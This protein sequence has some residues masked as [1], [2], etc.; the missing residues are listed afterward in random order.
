[1]EERRS[2]ARRRLSIP[3]TLAASPEHRLPQA[4][5]LDISLDGLLLA[6]AEPV[7]FPVGHR[8]VV[9]LQL[10]RGHFHALGNVVRVERGDD[11]RFYMAM[12]F[13]GLRP[14]DYA[15]LEHQLD[16]LERPLPKGVGSAADE[17]A[18]VT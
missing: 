18:S 11:D 5:T 15:E 10:P 1:M 13:T 16:A 2:S 7:G 8:L 4:E 14:D 9:S 3:A 6:F 12:A 17:R